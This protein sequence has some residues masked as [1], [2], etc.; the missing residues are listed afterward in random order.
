MDDN[1]P[2]T[3]S[4][5]PDSGDL[6]STED[7]APVDGHHI[8]TEGTRLQR[9]LTEDTAQ[10]VPQNQKRALTED[11]TQ[12]IPQRRKQVQA[13]DTAQSVALRSSN[14]QRRRI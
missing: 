12:F 11:T 6:L 5:A 4:P 1:G 9:A 7:M 10:S 13:E 14:R 2:D 8:Q 3:P